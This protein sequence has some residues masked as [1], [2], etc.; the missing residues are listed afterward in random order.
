MICGHGRHGKDTLCEYLQ[1]RGFRYT[2]SSQVANATN[3]G[4]PI[5]SAIPKHPVSLAISAMA[6]TIGT[7]AESVAAPKPHV[8]PQ[9]RGLLRRN[10]R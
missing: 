4:E 9:K 6:R 5:A 1:T 3:S 7:P 8:E 10:S 2:S